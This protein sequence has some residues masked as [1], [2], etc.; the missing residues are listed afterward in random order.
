M[1][2]MTTI[3]STKSHPVIPASDIA[4]TS[5]RNLIDAT[6]DLG[7]FKIFN[8]AVDAAGLT[9][10]LKGIGPF[11]IFAPTDE[12][13]AKI[14]AGRLEALFKPEN[15]SELRSLL[16]CH[17]VNGK[18]SSPELLMASPVKTS[19]GITAIFKAKGTDVMI[20]DT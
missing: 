19:Q 16:N 3:A 13:F 2:N 6:T 15:K 10:S 18:F 11:T 4:T 12:A 9:D 5:K 20:D 1:N 17:I 8:R 14:P 7:K